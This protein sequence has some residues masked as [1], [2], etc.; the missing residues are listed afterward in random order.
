MEE[1]CQLGN[2][3]AILGQDRFLGMADL[4]EEPEPFGTWERV[5]DLQGSLEG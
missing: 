5:I 3:F 4:R 1:I 2:V